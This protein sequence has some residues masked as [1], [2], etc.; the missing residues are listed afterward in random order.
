MSDVAKLLEDL[1]RQRFFGSL[2]IKL[3]AGRV[4]LM[5]KTEM[6][7]PTA[8]DCRNNRGTKDEHKR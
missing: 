8:D 5:R 6:L 4:V 7:K 1:E 3:E 2:E